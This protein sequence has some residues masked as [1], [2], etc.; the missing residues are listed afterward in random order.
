M[1]QG[2]EQDL[3]RGESNH[4]IIHCANEHDS[5]TRGVE[6]VPEDTRTKMGPRG[7]SGG[8]AVLP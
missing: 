6:K 7:H 1:F 2:S 3:E 5:G 4:D 8:P